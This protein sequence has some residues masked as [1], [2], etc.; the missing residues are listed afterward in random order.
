MKV[1]EHELNA[2]VDGQV[3]PGRRAVI[4]AYLAAHPEESQRIAAYAGQRRGLHALYDH[5]LADALPEPMQRLG[6]QLE[7][8]R[9]WSHRRRQATRMAAAVALVALGAGGFMLH[10]ALV[11][12]PQ[13]RALWAAIVDMMS[14]NE[15][16]R[17]PGAN[18]S[19][20]V[21][22]ALPPAETAAPA[23]R[24]PAA[25]DL[26]PFGY[27][28]A[29][30]R[31]LDGEPAGAAQFVYVDRRGAQVV[32]YVAPT[33]QRNNSVSVL[34]EGRVSALSLNVGGRSVLVVGEMD[35]ERLLRLA[36]IVMESWVTGDRPAA[37]KAPDPNKGRGA[38]APNASPQPAPVPEPQPDGKMPRQ[39]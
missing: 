24:L 16:L 11:D 14:G 28:L 26:S 18:A 12:R 35:R 34:Q 9:I 7:R 37:P 15:R 10:Q 33:T 8:G 17:P 29:V 19:P 31:I 3:E 39:S 23:A 36:G 30:T 20:G 22:V 2:Y 5:W 13:T 25:P 6:V 21:P 38:A 4:E 32:M 1:S 27:A